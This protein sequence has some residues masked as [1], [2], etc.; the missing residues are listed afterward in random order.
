M[1]GTLD[2]LERV[3]GEGRQGGGGTEEEGGRDESAD[4]HLWNKLYRET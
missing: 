1:S 3:D 4:M 2:D